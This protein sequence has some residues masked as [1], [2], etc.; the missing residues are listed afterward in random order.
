MRR[1]S[2]PGPEVS[3]RAGREPFGGPGA[4]AT[5]TKS[6][7]GGPEPAVP[8]AA[9]GRAAEW[10]AGEASAGSAASPA[11]VAVAGDAAADGA[12]WQLQPLPGQIQKRAKVSTAWEKKVSG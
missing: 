9:W 6:P 10:S 8:A 3:H 7:P 2:N 1:R 12:S 4:E 11:A 5:G